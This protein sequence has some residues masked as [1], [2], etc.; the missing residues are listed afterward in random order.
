MKKLD[1]MYT[2]DKREDYNNQMHTLGRIFTWISLSIFILVPIAYCL[3]AKTGPNW[4]KLGALIPSFV[5]GYWA[6][7]LIEAISYAPLLGT[8]GQYLSFITGNIS[9]LKLPAAINA[10]TISKVK[11]G[12]EEQELVT[13]IA[14]AVSSIVTTVII[15]IGLIPLIIWQKEIVEILTPIS[16]YVMP[17]IFGALTL[18]VIAMYAKIA[19][20][21][22]LICTIISIIANALGK[23]LGVATMIIVGMVVSAIST[24]IMYRIQNKKIAAKEKA[25]IATLTESDAK[26]ADVKD[27]VVEDASAKNAE[28]TNVVTEEV[29]EVEEITEEEKK[30]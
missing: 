26:D 7:G 4:A 11:P 3:A 13:T 14:I 29:V 6:I 23:D 20:I 10:Q 19:A 12:S 9:N 1:L 15:L 8:G 22:F 2:P 18:V 25:T 27:A 5:L 28:E 24:A 30:E 16:P 17:A 21:P